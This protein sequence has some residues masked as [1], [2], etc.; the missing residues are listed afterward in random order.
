MCQCMYWYKP[1]LQFRNWTPKVAVIGCPCRMFQPSTLS[2]SKIRLNALCHLILICTGHKVNCCC[3]KCFNT[4][5]NDKLLDVSKLK[6][7]ADDKINVTLKQKFFFEIDRNIVG[8]GENAG[9]QHFL[10]FPQCFQK[11]SFSG[12]LKVRIV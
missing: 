6:A 3:E 4:L 1:N 5:P 10:I 11:V 12:S 8:K 9:Y 2:R 7:F